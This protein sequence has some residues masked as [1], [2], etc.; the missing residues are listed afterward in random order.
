MLGG[1]E[2]QGGRGSVQGPEQVLGLRVLRAPDAHA[3]S[4]SEVS[5]ITGFRVLLRSKHP[6]R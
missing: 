3:L 6:Q 4:Q 1:E 5:K 2:G